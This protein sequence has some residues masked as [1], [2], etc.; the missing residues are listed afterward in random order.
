MAT[1]KYISLERLQGYDTLIKQKIADSVAYTDTEISNVQTQL[2]SVATKTVDKIASA[3]LDTTLSS[4]SYHPNVGVTYGAERTL[5]DGNDETL[6]TYADI[7]R[8]PIVAGDNVTFTVDEDTQVVKINAGNSSKGLSY[9]LNDDGNSYSVS[10]IGTCTDTDIV[11]PSIYEGKPVTSIADSAFRGSNLISVVIPDSVASIGTYAFAYCDYLT[12]IKLSDSVTSIKGGTFLSCRSLTHITIPDSVTSIGV[13][14]FS[15][16]ESLTSIIIPDSVISISDG[17]FNFCSSLKE[18]ALPSSLGFL[19]SGFASSGLTKIKIPDSINIISFRAF[20]G[21][22][23]LEQVIIPDS[24]NSIEMGAFGECEYL[25]DVYYKGSKEQWKLISIEE[26]NNESLLN[27]TIHYNFADDFIKVNNAIAEAVNE[28]KSE[29]KP[30]QTSITYSKLKALRDNSELIPGMFY[31]ITDYQCTTVQENTRA[32]DNKFDIIVQALSTS[33]LSENASAD[34][35]MGATINSSV[36]ESDGVLV[37]GSVTW[38]YGICE[39]CDTLENGTNDYTVGTFRGYGNLQNNEGIIVPVLYKYEHDEIDYGDVFY[40]VGTHT[41]NGTTYDKW[42]KIEEGGY[43]WDSTGKI[44]ALTNVIVE[45]GI[46]SNYFANSNL[47][48][49]ELKYCLDNDT[50]RFA[51]TLEGQVITNVDSANSYGSPLLRQPDFDGKGSGPQTFYYAWGVTADL[52]DGDSTNFVYSKTESLSNGDIVFF[53]GAGFSVEVSSGKG[54]I[55]YM[56]DE[57]G[58]ECPYDFKNIQFKR[59]QGSFKNEGKNITLE[60]INMRDFFS[61]EYYDAD[62]VMDYAQCCY[63]TIKEAT[64][65]SSLDN[66]ASFLFSHGIGEYIRIDSLYNENSILYEYLVDKGVHLQYTY[67][68]PLAYHDGEGMVT[69][70]MPINDEIRYCWFYTFSDLSVNNTT[71]EIIDIQDS[72]VTSDGVGFNKIHSAFINYGSCKTQILGENIFIGRSIQKNVIELNCFKNTFGDNCHGNYLC[73]NVANSTFDGVCNNNIVGTN[74]YNNLFG[75]YSMDNKVG[76]SSYANIICN[77]NNVLGYGC[78]SN[79]IQANAYNN[80]FDNNCI[81]NIVRKNSYGNTFE[82][83][84]NYNTIDEAIYG[85][86]LEKYVSDVKVINE[87]GTDISGIRVCQGISGTEIKISSLPEAPIVYKPSGYKEIILD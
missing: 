38:Y 77:N 15:Q 19:Y 28:V 87:T 40:Y 84:C 66:L 80:H 73:Y 1:K 64:L 25:T 24:V 17:A 58:N 69:C 14:A 47:A 52:E 46:S 74:S 72:S 11:I 83:E 23:S 65:S 85:S 27:A 50:D 81:V 12:R 2:D 61:Y 60:L 33:T 57:H 70:Y 79:I 29:V 34:Y 6:A 20:D 35:P 49:W 3:D 55:Y 62:Y 63:D 4:L 75:R 82:S 7:Q 59:L 51:W 67:I 8:T 45:G 26:E 78:S 16:C 21:C 68:L 42:R 44:Y 13:E 76:C 53:D 9:T 71:N 5:L 32:M 22:N 10:G 36:I 30:S 48:A 31:R 41:Y 18:V 56:K 54:V 39:D 37:E 86:V 43:N